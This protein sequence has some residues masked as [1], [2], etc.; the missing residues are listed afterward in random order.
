MGGSIATG[1]GEEGTFAS[2]DPLMLSGSTS[3]D[4]SIFDDNGLFSPFLLSDTNNNAN[5]ALDTNY[6][7]AF[8]SNDFGEG[9]DY[10]LFDATA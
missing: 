2:L 1:A 4:N 8:V 6:D 10:S 3:S 9:Q 5:V 7:L